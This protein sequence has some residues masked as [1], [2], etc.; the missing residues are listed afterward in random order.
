MARP[1]PII[2]ITDSPAVAK[3]ENTAITMSAA[4]TTT[5][6]LYRKPVEIESPELCPWTYASRMRETRKTS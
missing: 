3:P 6:A 1:K 4:A 5:R 2:L